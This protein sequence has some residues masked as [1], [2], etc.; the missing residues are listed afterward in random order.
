M[1]PVWMPACTGYQKYFQFVLRNT[2]ASL[3]PVVFAASVYTELNSIHNRIT[4][5][6]LTRYSKPTQYAANGR[7]EGIGELTYSL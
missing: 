2:G 7:V 3:A 5:V 6:C 4:L 1:R